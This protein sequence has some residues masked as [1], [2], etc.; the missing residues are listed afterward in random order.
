MRPRF[1]IALLCLAVGLGARAEQIRVAVTAP[2][3]EGET[4]QAVG[5]AALW[6]SLVL[7][8]LSR[9][10]WVSLVDRADL[11]VAA[12]E[13]ALA[14][15]S[16]NGSNAPARPMWQG[17]DLL[18]IGRLS[19]T[20]NLCALSL[21][22]LDV[23]RGAMAASL[24]DTFA[25]TN[26]D[27]HVGAVAERLRPIAL[28]WLARRDI[29]TLASVLDFDLESRF[30]R[31]RWQ[32]K[33]LVRRLRAFLQQQ[34]G[35]LVLER[36]DVEELLHETR[37]QRGGLA[38]PGAG[39]T[40]G[41]AALRHFP[42]VSG[43]LTETQPEGA[44]LSLRIVTRVRD[45]ASGASHEFQETFPA[46]QWTEGVDRIGRRLWA[47]M[48]G[49]SRRTTN[50]AP[51]ADRSREA[52]ELA[53][54][55]LRLPGSQSMSWTIFAVRP[56]PL[57]HESELRSLFT[58]EAGFLLKTP[59]RRAKLLQA[60]QYLKAAV[61]ADDSNPRIKLL[62]ASFLADPQ[63][64]E[65]ALASELAEEAGW[66]SSKDR[67]GAW[68]FALTFAPADQKQRLRGLL[69][70]FFPESA[71]ARPPA[72]DPLAQFVKEHRNDEDLTSVVEA[73]RPQLTEA[74]AAPSAEW[75]LLAPVSAVFEATQLTERNPSGRPKGRELQTAEN[76]ARGI[77]LL[78]ELAAQHPKHA[79]SLW[80]FW[81]RCW[82]EHTENEAEI[83]RWQ[84]RA[85]DTAPYD[86]KDRVG[87]YMHDEPR[88]WMSRRLM[89]E[90]KFKEAIPYLE[91][92]TH[93]L[94]E[95]EHDLRLARCAFET[96]DYA[97]ALELYRALRKVNAEAVIW[98][99]RC[100]EKL[101]LP[102]LRLEYSV[103]TQ[104]ADWRSCDLQLPPVRALVTNA[105]GRL[106]PTPAL[107]THIQA[108]AVTDE[109]VWL[110]IVPDLVMFD[111]NLAMFES[112]PAQRVNALHHGR[113]V[114]W[115]R[116]TGTTT[117]YTPAEGLPN[118]WVW[119]LAATADGVWA[120]TRGGGIGRL[121]PRTGRWRIWTE[122]NGLPMNFVRC[123]AADGSDVV[124][125]F[126]RGESG[127]V[128]KYSARTGQWRTL[129]REDFPAETNV[130]SA[131]VLKAPNLPPVV[132]L[133]RVVSLVPVTPV[134]Q[135]AS[136][137]GRVWC[138]VPTEGIRARPINE[139][140]I[141][142]GLLVG[143]LQS[144]GWSQAFPEAPRS[145]TRVGDRVWCSL[146]AGGLAHCDLRGRDWQRITRAEGLPFD[147]GPLCEW[148]GRLLMAGDH[149]M[150]L[151]PATKRF[152][153][154]PYPT[155]GGAGLM[156]LAKD[157]LYLVRGTQI[158]W[159]DLS[160]LAGAN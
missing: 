139:S 118:P 73:L 63:V 104:R 90:G 99:S 100:E 143:D 150:V 51:A 135:L 112:N 64:Q 81:A 119:A 82:T 121:N 38:I 144:N 149:F 8:E 151:E 120:G 92:V 158:L 12:Q 55:A 108:L 6:Q 75:D 89:D 110:G 44:P 88:L 4:N 19:L 54:K 123:L 159:L 32:Q 58:D 71:N 53:D 23:A 136:L 125:G 59:S 95:T 109:D 28:H 26:L 106:M 48:A 18:V 91:K 105:G 77:A 140:P 148:K 42:L 94:N 69:A 84:R 134:S 50:A 22:V 34:P 46:E 9:H 87:S 62:L 141:P 35:V 60:V 15:A 24:T 20:N 40:N 65:T 7:T 137:E 153:I 160:T 61:L 127:G 13:W 16:A 37:L 111:W 93:E 154:Y 85:A 76:R 43:T 17:A 126:G 2:V 79:F 66:Q 157:R 86:P 74:L 101:G 36:E 116:S 131:R 138:S 114:R 56:S 146:G 70:Q 68:A 47:E 133:T 124:A 130:P 142:A 11:P 156:A 102:P 29:H 80:Y 107:S 83:L 122:T 21:K 3:V 1:S 52:M 67:Y 132:Q 41:W 103:V 31:S 14:V 33:A 49:E 78:E 45:L 30:N 145:I 117:L 98:A 147:P 25:V 39:N 113:L 152:V 5:Q 155:P 10:D 27:T 96:A 57:I 128:A 72:P 129:L 115:N 97:R